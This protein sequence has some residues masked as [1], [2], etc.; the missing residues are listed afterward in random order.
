[1]RT[2]FRASWAFQ[3]RDPVLPPRNLWDISR[4]LGALRPG[5]LVTVPFTFWTV[6]DALRW[7]GLEGEIAVYAPSSTYN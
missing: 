7:F 1:M 4:L 2:L 6:G 3:G 5:T